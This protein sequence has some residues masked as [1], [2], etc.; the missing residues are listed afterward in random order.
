MPPGARVEGMHR[1]RGVGGSLPH[2]ALPRQLPRLD[3]CCGP[4]GGQW[5]CCLSP[6]TSEFPT[7]PV[8]NISVK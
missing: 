7:I 3:I 4:E 5:D 6:R 2:A 1:L 8:F